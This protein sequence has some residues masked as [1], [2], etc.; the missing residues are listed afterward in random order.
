MTSH[1]HKAGRAFRAAATVG[2]PAGAIPGSGY[3][4]SVTHAPLRV[5]LNIKEQSGENPQHMPK[6]AVIFLGRTDKRLALGIA[7]GDS[8]GYVPLLHPHAGDCHEVGKAATPG[9]GRNAWQKCFAQRPGYRPGPGMCARAMSC[10]MEYTSK[11]SN[12]G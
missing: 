9:A 4:H 6:A 1:R 11:N 12:H 7:G 3:W 10:T 8:H 5:S 2:C